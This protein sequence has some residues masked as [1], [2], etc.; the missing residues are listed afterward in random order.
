[1]KNIQ[2]QD[3]LNLEAI[4]SRFNISPLLCQPK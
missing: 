3:F 1:M 4:Q 2:T